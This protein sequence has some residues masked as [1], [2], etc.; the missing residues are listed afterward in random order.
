MHSTHKHVTFPLKIN[1]PFMR[2]LL[3][4]C[5]LFCS[6]FA[7][8]QLPVY[9]TVAA[10]SGLYL[11]S[12]PDAGSDRVAWLPEGQDVIRLDTA[13]H[14]PGTVVD[15]GERIQGEWYWVTTMTHKTGYLFSH[16]LLPKKT[17]AYHN[18]PCGDNYDSCRVQL[19]TKEYNF[20]IYGFSIEGH[21][22][23]LDT[24]HLY[25]EVFFE[26]GDQMAVL[27]T[28]HPGA[29]VELWYTYEERLWPYDTT[30]PEGDSIELW[31]GAE[32]FEKISS[33]QDKYY[34]LPPTPY[35][36][37]M[38]FREEKM[39]LIRVPDWEEGGEGGWIPRFLYRGVRHSYVIEALLLKAILRYPDGT[40]ATRYI[41][42]SLSYGC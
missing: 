4:L 40:A 37:L 8:A 26:I 17:E 24:L 27:E 36:E 13:H 21:E 38:E 10:K 3:T 6:V 42:I 14:F 5:I 9:F 22:T 29:S 7:W 33:F 19:Y 20:T 25:E 32:P 11:R 16:W 34:R 30:T 1:Q 2:T 28:I 41:R 12:A 31:I 23:N 35:N 15:E 18:G 39:G